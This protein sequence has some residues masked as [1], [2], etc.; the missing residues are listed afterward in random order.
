MSAIED[1]NRTSSGVA[2]SL[3]PDFSPAASAI[4]VGNI[5]DNNG[6]KNRSGRY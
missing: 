1:Q 2:I 3:T 5:E 6:Y 4:G